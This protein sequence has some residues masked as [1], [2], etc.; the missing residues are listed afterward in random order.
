MHS[1]IGPTNIN[2]AA[3][4]CVQCYSKHKIQVQITQTKI[5]T[6]STVNKEHRKK[7]QRVVKCCEENKVEVV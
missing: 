2:L 1:F 7:G 5:F 6:G 3:I 4:K